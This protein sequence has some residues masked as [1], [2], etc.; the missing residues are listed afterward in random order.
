MLDNYTR[1]IDLK[2]TVLVEFQTATSR[3]VLCPDLGDR[4]FAKVGGWSMHRINLD[5]VAHPN[6]PFNN[7]GGGEVSGRRPKGENSASITRVTNGTFI[8]ERSRA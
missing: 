3:L 1:L 2:K 7:F 4:T 5:A 6:R 8:G